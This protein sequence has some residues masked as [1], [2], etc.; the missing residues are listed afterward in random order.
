MASLLQIILAARKK[1]EVLKK[2]HKKKKTPSK[3]HYKY[4]GQTALSM[5]RVSQIQ[6]IVAKRGGGNI[7]K[8]SKAA[9]LMSET[10]KHGLANQRKVCR[11]RNGCRC[12][13]TPMRPDAV[14]RIMRAEAKRNGGMVPKGSFA[15]RAQRAASRN[16][17]GTR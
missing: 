14:A 8:G 2:M 10:A 17:F 5:K 1:R 3:R 12:K 11:I 16:C 13:R 4:R 6:S 7:E 15:A 9:L